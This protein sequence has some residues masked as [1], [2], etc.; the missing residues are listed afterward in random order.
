[1]SSKSMAARGTK[2]R[3]QSDECGLP[4]YD[5][6]R[7]EMDCPMC[8]ASFDLA[9]AMRIVPV[10]PAK[11]PVRGKPGRYFQAVAPLAAVPSPIA[12]A[13]GEV[14]AIDPVDA[15][16]IE[17]EG[18]EEDTGAEVATVEAILED[19]DDPVDAIVDVVPEDEGRPDE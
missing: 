13:D 6:N 17:V 1:M 3:C 4:F 15:E 9:A 16:D 5:L 14:E 18:A 2:R 12:D 10:V 19:E 11:A 7:S 8:G